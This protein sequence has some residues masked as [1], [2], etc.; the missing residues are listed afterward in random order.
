MSWNDRLYKANIDI[1]TATTT[2]VI[3]AVAGKR[4]AID[5]INMLSAGTN[6]VTLKDGSTTYGAGYPLAAQV[7][8]ALD[9]VMKNHD[10]LITLSENSAFNITTS[11][12]VQLSGFVRY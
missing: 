7:G 2:A 11:A 1:S 5:H 8:M 10:G 9:N 3:A 12:S 6:T 4:I